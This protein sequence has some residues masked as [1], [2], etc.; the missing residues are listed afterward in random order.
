M[1]VRIAIIGG[2]LAGLSA[3]LG[4][5][6]AAE[7]G[8]V[9]IDLYERKRSIGSLYKS[10]GAVASYWLNRLPFSIPHRVV[11]SPI[12]SAHVH[13]GESSVEIRAD[14]PIGAVLSQP[15]LEVELYRMALERAEDK[16]CRLSVHLGEFVRSPFDMLR[17]H[18]YLIGADGAFSLV[19]EQI[20]GPIPREEVHKCAEYL[21]DRP[22]DGE[23]HIF[24]ADYCPRGYIWVIPSK[25]CIKVGAGIPLSDRGDPRDIVLKFL[26]EHPEYAGRIIGRAYGLVPTPTPLDGV[27]RGRVAL[28]GD[29]GRLVNA[30]TGGGIQFAVLSGYEAGRS[31][32]SGAGFSAYEKWYKSILPMLRRWR[33]VKSV[34]WRLSVDDLA[35]VAEVVGKRL[36][37]SGEVNPGEELEAV[38]KLVI[39]H[40]LLAAKVGA[41]LL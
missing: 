23:L 7:P 16:S 18:D 19:A 40:P 29:A 37:Y 6:E 3:A 13:A 11:E 14:G 26:E 25:G 36:Y 4:A 5:L 10:S 2:G 35:K 12:L 30:A 32:G 24:F 31:A 38:V 20:A 8:S 15:S 17:T 21:I 33:K 28:V 9:E 41:A 22:G 27:A 39:N 1:V 34:L